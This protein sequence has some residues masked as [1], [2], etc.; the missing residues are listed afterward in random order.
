MKLKDK[1]KIEA[2]GNDRLRCYQMVP[3]TEINYKMQKQ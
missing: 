3:T 2:P 1:Y